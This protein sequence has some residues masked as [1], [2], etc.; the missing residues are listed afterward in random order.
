MANL[1][2]WIVRHCEKTDEKVVSFIVGQIGS[3]NEFGL[4]DDKIGKLLTADELHLLDCEVDI[5]EG[6]AVYIWTDKSVLFFQTYDVVES[7]VSVPR[8]PIVREPRMFGG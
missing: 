6:S 5:F 4:P 3:S 7:L 1:K 2:S 8:N